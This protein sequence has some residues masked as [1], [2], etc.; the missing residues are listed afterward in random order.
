MK[1]YADM[2][3]FPDFSVLTG[4]KAV[5]SYLIAHFFGL[6]AAMQSLAGLML[7]DLVTGL[8]VGVNEKELNS[9]KGARGVTKKAGIVAI[10]LGVNIATHHLT[11]DRGPLPVDLGN[12]ITWFY[13]VTELVSIVENCGKLG[14]PI[15]RGLMDALKKAQQITDT[16][17]AIAEVKANQA[18]AV[19]ALQHAQEATTALEHTLP[20]TS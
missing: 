5:G 2:N 14:A 6:P 16:G 13:V 12:W 11:G 1:R 20:P 10:I 3:P 18:T 8:S 19:V 15:P 7:L 9:R 17:E 4:A